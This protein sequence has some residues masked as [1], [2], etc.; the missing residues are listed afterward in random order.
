[1]SKRRVPGLVLRGG[2][3]HIQKTVKMFGGK[4]ERLRESTGEREIEK[5]EAYLARRLAE[6]ERQ[7]V[8]GAR[9]SRT[10]RDAAVKYLQEA[11]KAGKKSVDRD[12]ATLSILE[13]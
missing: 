11:K 8:H 10:W 9:P 5:A 13:E 4:R 12:S 2:V 6:I 1:M 3:W 7:V